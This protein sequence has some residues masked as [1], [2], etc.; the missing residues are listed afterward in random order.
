MR[1]WP[2]NSLPAGRCGAAVAAGVVVAAAVG[3]GG[4]RFLVAPLARR[5]ELAAILLI[6]GGVVLRELLLG[7]QPVRI[8]FPSIERRDPSRRHPAR[9]GRGDRG[10]GG[11]CCGRQHMGD[12]QHPGRR[13]VA[14]HGGH[15]DS[16]ELIGVDTARVRTAAFAV[17]GALAAGAALL[18]A[19]RLPIAAA[20]GV[21]LA[22]KGIAAAVAGGLRSPYG[23]RG[24][25]VH[26]RRS[27]WWEPI[28]R[29]RR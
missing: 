23:V 10:C 12:V 4:E 28:S 24:R 13:R 3:A 26:R 16:A 27:R 2:P 7:L 6:A 18:A 8:R 21:P 17:A 19:G 11:R 29:R 20:A 22:L 25:G 15:P 1:W 9:R 14:G 5:V